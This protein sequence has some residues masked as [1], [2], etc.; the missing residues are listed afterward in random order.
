MNKICWLIVT[1]VMVMAAGCGSDDEPAAR[2]ESDVYGAWV[3]GDGDYFYFKYPNICYRLVPAASE[4]TYAALYNDSYFYEPGYRFLLYIDTDAQPNIYEVTSLTD[5]EMTWVWADNL[6]DDKYDGM[7]GS[8]ILGQVIKEAQDG[9]KLDYSRT[10]QFTKIS[11]DDFKKILED[12]G[13][14][15][16]AGEL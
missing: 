1:V 5:R 14:S 12:A 13:Y 10:T 6:R 2:A 15:Y 8:E 9:F 11:T 7:S 4:D 3:D 16:E